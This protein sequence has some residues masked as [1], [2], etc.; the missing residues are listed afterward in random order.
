MR[1][2]SEWASKAALGDIPRPVERLTRSPEEALAFARQLG[3]PVVAKAG[4]VAH[5]SDFGAVRLGLDPVRLGAAW[6]ELAALGD[7]TVLVAEQVA[8]DLELIIGGLRDPQFGP[9]V[10]VGLGGV[11][12][13]VFKDVVFVL[14]PP[15]P[16]ELERALGELRGAALL[17]GHRGGPAV[18]RAAVGKI[19][20]A[21]ARL[22][23]ED[24]SVVEVDC[25]PVL[26]SGGKP[27]VA[28]ALVVKA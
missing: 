28:D 5:K 1:T 12:A 27:V 7:G 23:L 21:V 8:A 9:V 4:G 19:V 2:L 20:D 17:D 25:N 16:E 22:L 15:L 11:A 24:E 10:S 18:D 6:P 26:V 13:E 14:A 3:R